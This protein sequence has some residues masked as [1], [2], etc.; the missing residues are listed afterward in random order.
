MG[1]NTQ[2]N[3]TNNQDTD[4]DTR[5]VDYGRLFELST[6]KLNEKHNLEKIKQDLFNSAIT[7]YADIWKN[8]TY[9]HKLLEKLR[10]DQIT[11]KHCTFLV[12]ELYTGFL[13]KK[14]EYLYTRVKTISALYFPM[15]MVFGKFI[16]MMI[17]YVIV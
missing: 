10:E 17:S 3:H 9:G 1:N 8:K 6:I 16:S 14:T 7:C 12:K 13:E 15:I 4:E 5:E 11:D 2:D